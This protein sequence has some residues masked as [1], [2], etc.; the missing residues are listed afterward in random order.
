M[1]THINNGLIQNYLKVKTSIHK[2]HKGQDNNHHMEVTT[3]I[4]LNTHRNNT[5]QTSP[6]KH[7]D[8]ILTK[9]HFLK[10]VTAPTTILVIKAEDKTKEI[11]PTQIHI[12]KMDTHKTEEHTVQLHQW[13]VLVIQD[14]LMIMAKDFQGTIK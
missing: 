11:V 3:C 8:N 10:V 5:T 12:H 2:I 14:N 6:I 13:V 1:T 4:L 9:T 7:R